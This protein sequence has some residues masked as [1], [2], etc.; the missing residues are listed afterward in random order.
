MRP[1]D[2]LVAWTS[3]GFLIGGIVAWMGNS[4]LLHVLFWSMSLAL[5]FA[6]PVLIT[7]A[8]EA[9]DRRRRWHRRQD[10]EQRSRRDREWSE[11]S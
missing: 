6:L 7:L 10:S 2:R 9:H 4:D 8:I 3:L 11:T 1:M 5:A